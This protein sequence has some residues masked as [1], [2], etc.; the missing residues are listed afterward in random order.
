MAIPRT[1]YPYKTV[2]SGWLSLSA[3]L[4]G[5]VEGVERLTHGSISAREATGAF[6]V[7]FVIESG[8]PKALKALGPT[9]SQSDRVSINVVESSIQSRRRVKLAEFP[10]DGGS[11]NVLRMRYDPADSRGDIEVQAFLTY[12]GQE[13]GVL[14]GTRCAESDRVLVHFDGFQTPPGSGIEINWVDFTQ[15]EQYADVQGELFVLDLLTEPPVLLLNEGL[16]DL[17]IILMSGANRGAVARVKESQF[18]LIESQVWNVMITE[19]LSRL[20]DTDND[21]EDDISD[22]L[23]G[24]RSHVLRGWAPSLMNDPD[25]KISDLAERMAAHPDDLILNVLPRQIQLRVGAGHSFSGL[26]NQFTDGLAT[27]ETDGA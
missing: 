7:E 14:P 15:E 27:E 23:G 26:A 17:K 11:K 25:A 9:A 24:W 16:P 19:A 13:N 3:E 12:T 2:R 6:D 20:A 8:S 1:F 4:V 21:D 22:R 18:A 10:L 5:E